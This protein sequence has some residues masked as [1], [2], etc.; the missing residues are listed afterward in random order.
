MREFDCG[1]AHADRDLVAAFVVPAVVRRGV[2]TP[3]GILSAGRLRIYGVSVGRRF[4]VVVWLL[5][6]SA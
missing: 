2:Q 5:F 6:V 4:T 1:A 3:I